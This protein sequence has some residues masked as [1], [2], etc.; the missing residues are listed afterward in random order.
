M[1]NRIILIFVL[2]IFVAVLLAVTSVVAL[3]AIAP[4]HAGQGLFQVQYWVEHQI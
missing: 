2:A 4:L 1:K 3:A